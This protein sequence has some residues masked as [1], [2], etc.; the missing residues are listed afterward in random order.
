MQWE[1]KWNQQGSNTLNKIKWEWKQEKKQL[2]DQG[3][4]QSGNCLEIVIFA[5]SLLPMNP[6]QCSREDLRATVL[7]E[8]VLKNWKDGQETLK[9]LWRLLIPTVH[10]FCGGGQGAGGV[11]VWANCNKYMI[12]KRCDSVRG[13]LNTHSPYFYSLLLSEDC[14]YQVCSELLSLSVILMHILRS[15]FRICQL[16]AKDRLP[17]HT[18]IFYAVSFTDSVILIQITFFLSPLRMSVK[19]WHRNKVSP[20]RKR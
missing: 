3:A 7:K 17:L 10:Y 16:W 12:K 19:R 8:K 20:I 11:V 2:T 15:E 6:G 1:P 4:N 5:N 18:T 14:S 9:S 13:F